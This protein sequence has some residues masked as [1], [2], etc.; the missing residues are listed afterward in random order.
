MT[1]LVSLSPAEKLTTLRELDIFHRWDSIDE[2]RLCRRCGQII[3][4]QEI[5]VVESR[6]SRGGVRLE[7]PTEGCPSVPIESLMLE[8]YAEDAPE[9]L[10]EILQPEIAPRQAPGNSTP[11]DRRFFRFPRR[12]PSSSGNPKHGKQAPFVPEHCVATGWA[13]PCD[14]R[15]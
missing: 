3:S 14:V 12:V 11:P 2:K 15:L 1:D 5:S 6:H 9:P 13:A 10:L 4:G 7:C 8:P